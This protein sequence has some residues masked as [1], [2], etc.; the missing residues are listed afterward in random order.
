MY[1][2]PEQTLDQALNDIEQ[3][4]TLQPAHIS[5]YQLTLEPG[6]VFYHQPPPLPDDDAAWSMQ[7][8]CQSLLA[9]SG[10]QQY[11]VS[12]YARAGHQCQHNLNYWRF[13]DYVGLG[14][15]AH[16]KSPWALTA[17]AQIFYVRINNA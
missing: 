17:N 16:G 13:G 8:E 9:A 5:H 11:E 2:L 7:L 14:A 15:G 6:T 12:A 1:A 4:I 10:Y 3:A